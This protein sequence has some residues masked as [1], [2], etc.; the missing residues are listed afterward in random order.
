MKKTRKNSAILPNYKI[1]NKC[2]DNS[3]RLFNFSLLLLLFSLLVGCESPSLKANKAVAN[4]TTENEIPS[5]ERDLQTMR[6]A[7]FDFIYAFRRKDG[8]AFDGDDR[9]FLRA[10]APPQTNRFVSTDDGRVFI[11]G[12]GYK[13]SPEILEAL[14]KRF[15]VEDYSAK[16][17]E[18]RETAK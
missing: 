17:E 8:A 1:R 12:S 5:F 11:A 2:F 10:T 13:F 15:N 6:T 9:K 4:Q 14:G 16:K 18:T 7:N 3:G